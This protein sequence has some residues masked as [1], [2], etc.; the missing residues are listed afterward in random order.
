MDEDP[1]GKNRIWLEADKFICLFHGRLV[2]R[3]F[4]DV[5]G[6]TPLQKGV[7][8]IVHK[9][10]GQGDPMGPFEG[11][12]HPED[13]TPKEQMVLERRG[14]VPPSQPDL[15]DMIQKQVEKEVEW[16]MYK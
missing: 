15:K 16:H 11:N 4:Q 7:R 13:I 2:K 9:H 1:R 14:F 12:W 10:M 6:E 3:T 8:Q 5:L